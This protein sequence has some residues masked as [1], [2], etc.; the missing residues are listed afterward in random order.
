MK[1]NL[2]PWAALRSFEAAGRHESFTE[3]AQELFVSQAAISRQVRDLEAQLGKKLFRREH[4]QVR[5]TAEGSHLLATLTQSFDAIGNCLNE[6]ND[7]TPSSVLT[8]SIE[9]SFASCLLT[10][11]K[12]FKDAHPEI[13]LNLEADHRLID[14]RSHDAQLA[15]RFSPSDQTWDGTQSKH[16]LDV[17]VTPAIS[18]KYIKANMPLKSP[19]DLLHYTLLHEDNRD[20]WKKWFA[21]HKINSGEIE[22]GPIYDNAA[23]ILQA[24]IDGHGAGFCDRKFIRE[25]LSSGRL[26]IP[27]ESSFYQGSYWLVARDFAN[28]PESATSF[29]NW[30]LPRM[31]RFSQD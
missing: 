22:R 19:R 1:R 5:L 27:F 25:D 17:E 28:L 9:P 30:F 23:L 13:D 31:K 6:I 24:I 20:D 16:L 12:E 4:R 2:I 26:I 18:P 21:P 15:I 11:F 8:I 14:F 3:A 7:T 10:I 29:I